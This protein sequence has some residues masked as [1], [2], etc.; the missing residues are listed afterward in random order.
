VRDQWLVEQ[1]APLAFSG[2]TRREH[3]VL[4]FVATGRTNAETAA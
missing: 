4:D 3:D 2:L 1:P